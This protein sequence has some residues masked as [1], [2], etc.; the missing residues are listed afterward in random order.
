M[1]EVEKQVNG[2]GKEAGKEAG[3][4]SGV[5]VTA[6]RSAPSENFSEVLI[7]QRIQAHIEITQQLSQQAPVYL[8]V[9]ERLIEAFTTGKKA[10]L[11]G[12]GGSAAD[13]QHIAAEFVGKFYFDRPALPAQA[14]TVNT[15]SLTAI[16][17]DYAFDQV[18]SRQIEAFGSPG[19]VCVGISTSGNSRNVVEAFHA[20]QRKGI[21][22]VAL[23]GATGGEMA[24]AADYCIR[25]PSTD[26]PR[27][28]EHHILV[29]HIICELVEQALF[30]D[31]VAAR[32][33]R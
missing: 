13:A 30:A 1:T 12:N 15:S 5:R 32:E 3:K 2:A 24:T 9:A 14:L 26:T 29:G 10:L 16:G 22:T 23:T 21:I 7:M 17:N 8:Q 20:A 4:V 11:C 33:A 25:I 28:Q 18:F 27:I 19:D 6:E 31:V